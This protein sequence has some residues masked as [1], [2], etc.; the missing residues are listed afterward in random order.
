[1]NAYH[2][3][4][5]ILSELKRFLWPLTLDLDRMRP[6]WGLRG[7]QKM[8]I[9]QLGIQ[10]RKS[11]NVNEGN[12]PCLVGEFGCH[13]DLK[14]E[15]TFR[16]W[17]RSGQRAFKWPV[18]ALDLMYNAL[19]ALLLNGT[20]WNYTADNTNAFGDNWNLEDLSIFSRDQQ[21]QTDWRVDIN[22]GGRAIDG[23]CRPYARYISGTL[24]KMEYR[25]KKGTF[26]I[27]YEPDRKITAPSE[28]YI[29]SIQYPK[30]FNITCTGADWKQD[31]SNQIIW[32]VNPTQNRVRVVIMRK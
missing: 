2:W 24:L 22:A 28:I 25:R 11:Q 5:G 8:Y 3:Y 18:I 32:V 20:L 14:K 26:F 12:C 29:P 23:F 21:G 4:D 13:I 7:I 27:E 10:P 9:R 15:K 30:G 16:Q 6:V 31:E 1:M 19:D 17:I